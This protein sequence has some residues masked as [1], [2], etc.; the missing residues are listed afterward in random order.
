MALPRH[1]GSS[2]EC[3]QSG[4]ERKWCVLAV[5]SQFDPAETWR[6]KTLAAQKDG[7]GRVKIAAINKTTPA[8]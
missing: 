3:L 1:G 4:E 5:M 8:R 7:G 2:D 6:L